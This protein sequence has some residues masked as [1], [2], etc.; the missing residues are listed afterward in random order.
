[1]IRKRYQPQRS[2]ING[3]GL[4]EHPGLA[5]AIYRPEPR[6]Q[7][8]IS[9]GGSGAGSDRTG[10]TRERRSKASRSDSA[11]GQIISRQGISSS[12]PSL[13][14]RFARQDGESTPPHYRQPALHISS[15]FVQ[16]SLDA[17]RQ[18]V[19]PA[20]RPEPST[21]GSSSSRLS[22][23]QSAPAR[24]DANARATSRPA[25]N[26][27][28]Q[29]GA[30]R[31]ERRSSRERGPILPALIRRQ[32]SRQSSPAS[33]SMISGAGSPGS[34]T[35]PPISALDPFHAERPIPHT[36]SGLTDPTSWTS[37]TSQPGSN[38]MEEDRSYNEYTTPF[39][40][41][42]QNDDGRGKMG[43]SNLLS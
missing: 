22:K 40:T 23:K 13:S 25:A 34:R 38:A 8:R 19:Q 30:G 14:D 6:S 36:R 37:S 26:P 39:I 9:R 17:S 33:V 43:I 5:S 4:P 1:M 15:P 20:H 28:H 24:L 16:Y 41:H 29:V 12:L 18:A 11:A 2:T 27:G 21:S 32:L 10:G 31:R 7:V 3:A 42:T 35:L